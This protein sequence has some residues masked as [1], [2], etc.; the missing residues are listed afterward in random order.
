MHVLHKILV[1]NEDGFDTF[2]TEEERVDFARSTAEYETENYVN[3]VYDWR[4]T[5]SAGRWDEEYPKQVYF[6]ADDVDWFINEINDA[7]HCQELE[8]GHYQQELKEGIGLSL[9]TIIPLL[10]DRKCWSMAGKDN[11]NSMMAYCLLKLSRLL[12]GDYDIDSAIF[13]T[14]GYTAKIY[15]EDIEQI[16]QEPNKWAMVMFDYHY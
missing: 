14:R 11:D 2:E 5:D 13:N 15:N 1:Y 12:Y 7:I 9:E 10:K 4:E 8:I 6:A 3:E 16:K